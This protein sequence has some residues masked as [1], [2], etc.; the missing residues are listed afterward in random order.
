MAKVIVSKTNNLVTV[1]TPTRFVSYETGVLQASA[2]SSQGTITLTDTDTSQKVLNDFDITQ[3]VDTSDSVFGAT[4]S[5]AVTALNAVVNAAPDTFIKSTDKIT[6]LDGVD[7][8]D[9]TPKEGYG[10]FVGSSDE[11]L[12]TSDKFILGSSEITL[13]TDLKLNSA[14][15]TSNTNQNID[16]IPGGTGKVKLYNQYDFPTTDGTSGQVLQ[17]DGSGSLSF[18]DGGSGTTINNNAD[19][20]VITGSGTANTLEAEAKLTFSGSVLN[21]A[22]TNA[23]AGNGVS[24]YGG[25][26]G[27]ANAYISPVGAFSLLQFGDAETGSIFDMRRNKL[28]FDNDS[29]NTYIQADSSNPEN[30]EIHADGNIELR[31][32]DD[33]QVI[34]DINIGG[35]ATIDNVIADTSGLSATADIGHGAEI[36]FLGTSSTSTTIGKIYYYDGSTWQAFSSATEAAQKALLGYS[37]GSTMASGF[38]L[39]GFVHA[40]SSSLTAGAQVFGATNASATPTAPTSGFQRVIGHA[41]ANDI[42]YFNPSQDY[43]DL[44]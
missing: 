44:A 21:I 5:A 7:T 43:L 32:D 8:S 36:T 22:P 39:R 34:G 30:L 19:N 33:V 27:A 42:F 15:I 23:A 28:S 41:V 31:A 37:L 40:D 18:A 25:I 26:N 16:L 9:F 11:T 4:S 20:L 12:Q 10:V 17:T 29:T 38:L 3:L 35:S 13:S 24:I 1:Q 2:G 6:A 14:D